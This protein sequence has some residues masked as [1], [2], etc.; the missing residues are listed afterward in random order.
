[1]M[2]KTKNKLRELNSK[3]VYEDDVEMFPAFALFLNP[4]RYVSLQINTVDKKLKLKIMNHSIAG[5]LGK[6]PLS[7]VLELYCFIPEFP[8][9]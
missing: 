5:Q 4:L 7:P 1:M 9:L 2:T 6:M 8:T 3:D